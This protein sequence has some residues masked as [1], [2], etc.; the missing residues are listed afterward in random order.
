MHSGLPQLRAAVPQLQPTQVHGS[1]VRAG[2]AQVVVAVLMTRSSL[3]NSSG[4]YQQHMPRHGTAVHASRPS[5]MLAQP[6]SVYHRRAFTRLKLIPRRGSLN[7]LPGFIKYHLRVFPVLWT[8][9]RVA[10][11]SCPTCSFL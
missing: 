2:F 6:P 7:T 1:Q 11:P 4:D 10:Y 5:C 8:L 9:P 3:V